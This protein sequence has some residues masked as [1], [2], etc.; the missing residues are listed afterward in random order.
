MCAAIG[1][2]VYFDDEKWTIRHLVVDTGGWL[3]GRK[4]LI[5]PRSVVGVVT[6]NFPGTA[7]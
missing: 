7:P 4:V 3:S 5:S 6:C 1:D 2:A